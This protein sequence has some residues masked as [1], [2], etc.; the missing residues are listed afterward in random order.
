MIHTVNLDFCACGASLQSKTVQLL[1]SRLFPATVDNPRTAVT[2]R[3][4]E[5]FELLSYVSKVSAFEF[6]QS[7]SRLTDNT[8][9]NVPKVSLQQ[10]SS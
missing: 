5:L 10:D 3:A 2:F 8:G 6:Y 9:I 1:R 7:L 4:M